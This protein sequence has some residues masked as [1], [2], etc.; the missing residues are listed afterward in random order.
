MCWQASKR[1]SPPTKS[2]LVSSSPPSQAN[3]LFSSRKH[4]RE[5]KSLETLDKYQSYF[6]DL[7]EIRAFYFK[8]E[9][10]LLL[11]GGKGDIYDKSRCYL[12]THER[13]T[14]LSTYGTAKD[15]AHKSTPIWTPQQQFLKYR[16]MRT[17]LK[18]F[19]GKNRAGIARVSP[20]HI[21]P[22]RKS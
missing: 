7:L 17:P 16:S 12:L 1:K 2:I 15:I 19:D 3:D 13:F 22:Q 18:Q 11:R 14:N 8:D 9:L 21:L 4:T 20:T 10:G 5:G 6:H